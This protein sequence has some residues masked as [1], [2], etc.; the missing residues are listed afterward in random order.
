MAEPLAE[1][2]AAAARKVS[3][4]YGELEQGRCCLELEPVM[5]GDVW[6]DFSFEGSP[7]RSL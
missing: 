1:P 3:D 7:V 2:P 4:L 6:G 5:S